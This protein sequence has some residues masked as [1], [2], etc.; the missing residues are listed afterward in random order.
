[1][2]ELAHYLPHINAALNSLAAVFLVAGVLF[3]RA[4]KEQAHRRSMMSAFAISVV[5]LICYLVYHGIAGSKRFPDYPPAVVRSF[6]L[7]VLLTHIVLAA[8]VPFLAIAAIYFGLKDRRA[9][10]RR[11]VRWAFPIWLYV[12]VTGVIVYLMLYQ[13]YPPQIAGL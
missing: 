11:I 13:L 7:F 1:M 5:F 8:S 3:I 10:H 6:Y 12:S 9:K 2:A 4:G